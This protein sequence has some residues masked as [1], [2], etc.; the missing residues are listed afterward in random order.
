[1]EVPEDE[2]QR[3]AVALETARAAE[4]RCRW[5]GVDAGVG[6]L[7]LLHV[8]VAV[9][10]HL[11]CALD[12]VLQSLSLSNSQTYTYIHEHSIRAHNVAAEAA[13][14]TTGQIHQSS[15]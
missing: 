14:V 9:C 6:F 8:H 10:K 15:A 5:F 3:A 1:M 11:I 13:Q 12:I 2:E 7:L 4:N